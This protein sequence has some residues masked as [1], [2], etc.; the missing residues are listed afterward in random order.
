L[1]SNYDPALGATGT[2]PGASGTFAA[3]LREYRLEPDT[4]GRKKLTLIYR[5][6]TP[7]EAL[8]PGRAVLYVSLAGSAQKLLREWA[9]L[10]GA[11]NRVIEGPVDDKPLQKWVVVEGGNTTLVPGAVLRVRTVAQS[12]AL[13]VMWGL[14]GKY[15]ESELPNFMHAPARV[16]RFLGCKLGGTLIDRQYWMLDYLFDYDPNGWDKKCKSQKFKKVVV[17]LAAV[18]ADNAALVG[19]PRN[20]IGWV[21]EGAPEDRDVSRGP[22]NFS[23]LNGMLGWY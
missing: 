15:N 19:G 12:A 23:Y 4:A 10:P 20:I 6:P 17:N 7:E 21:E 3:Q 5:E 1:A 11:L 14:I 9:G 18:D 13:P 8:T 22:G 2:W 16:L